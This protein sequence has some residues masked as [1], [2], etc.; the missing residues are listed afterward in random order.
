MNKS[1]NT[2]S[3]QS[4]IPGPRT[5]P[6][7]QLGE[8]EW[9]RHQVL[10]AIGAHKRG[11][12]MS[13]VRRNLGRSRRARWLGVALTIMAIG[14]AACGGGGDAVGTTASPSTESD[15]VAGD[16][17][18]GEP[19][20]IK[21]R[22]TFAREVNGEVLDGSVIGDSPFCPGGRF[23]DRHGDDAIGLVDRTFACPDGSLRIGFTPGSPQGRTQSGPWKV[24]RQCW[25]ILSGT[26]AFE[27]LQGS[28]EMEVKYE[29]GSDT[30]GHETFTGTVLPS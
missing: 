5:G 25:W 26:G 20:L 17:A 29:R 8:L 2:T 7:Q 21:T 19:I 10:A 3:A 27:A 18:S 13:R 15:S 4:Q 14:V 22:V 1:L 9:R 12:I 6:A 23:Q 24:L 30:D 28:G 16:A 11:D